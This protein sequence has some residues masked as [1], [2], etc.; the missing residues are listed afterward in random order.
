V[1]LTS[2]DTE[3]H[4]VQ[5]G[6]LSPPIVCQ[7]FAERGTSALYGRDAGTYQLALRLA[8]GSVICGANI[9]YD[10]GCVLAAR[11]DLFPLVW[12]AYEESRVFDVQIAASLTA[13][14]DG[15]MRD[16]ELFRRDGTKIQS[17]RYSLDECVKEWLARTNAKEND[18]WR[19]SYALLE[20]VPLEEWPEDAR[21]YPIDDAVNTLEVAEAQLK[22]GKNLHDMPVQAWAAFCI[23]LGAVWGLRTDG[24]AV[25]E[26]K[27]NI[28]KHLLELNMFATSQ[29]FLR[30]NGS[31]DTK[32]IGERVFKAYDGNPPKTPTGKISISREALQDS[33]D[34]HLE[35]F[36][37][38]GKWEKLQTYIPTLEEA[39]VKPL[40]VKP[41]VLLSTG[42]V[43]YD[44]LVQ[45]MPRRGGVRECFVARPG[46]VMSSV[47]Y[48][49]IEMATLAQVCL[50]SVGFS[51]LADAINSDK[52]PHCI[53]GANLIG[54][55]YDSF[56]KRYKDGDKVAKSLRQ[57]GKAGNFGFPGMMGAAKFVIAQKKA[58][59]SVC[60]WFFAD[61]KCKEQKRLFEWRDEP[62]D[63]P[64]C[65]RCVEQAGVIREGY[66][67]QW[68]EVP[69]Y[70]NW[71]MKEIQNNDEIVQFVSKRVRGSP[72]G[73]AAANTLFQ[74]LAADGAKRAVIKM[75][76]EM[77][78][79]RETAL[80]GSR[81]VIFSHDETVLEIPRDLLHDAAYRQA[82]IMVEQMRTVV[83]DVI[84]KAEPA[85]MIRWSKDATTVH[86]ADGRLVPWDE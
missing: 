73:P 72:H 58:G 18:R 81:L 7:S 86:D 42:R 63:M 61:G 47:D 62:L 59:Y 76:G 77:Y 11:P 48:A 29:G 16:G 45:L 20:N 56:Y 3:T 1:S 39:A 30:A 70:W 37:E 5:S 23:H 53:I 6:L 78:G 4:L 35:R 25:A 19:L 55:S 24:V 26:L 68:K 57:A 9:A 15:R 50:W 79:V 22:D 12:K 17:G 31:K 44:G 71:V 64:L 65:S 60:E 36:A 82:E 80:T 38:V 52:D 14:A 51:E 13:I 83:P 2:W 84:V 8:N 28:E 66:L 85:A 54:S 49:A 10:F 67:Q 40:N 32:A 43:S 46:R 41:N 69:R 74:G 34:A 75:T 33:G 27:G 21:Q